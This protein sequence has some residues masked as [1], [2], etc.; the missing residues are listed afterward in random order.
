MPDVLLITNAQLI[1]G[2]PLG[3]NI[4]LDKYQSV[5]RDTQILT[6]EPILGTKLYNKILADYEANTLSG[7]YLELHTEYIVPILVHSTAAEYITISGFNVANG[8]IFR[9]TPENATPADKNEI[10][11][12]ANKQRSKADVYI[13]RLQK[14]LCDKNLPEYDQPQDENYDIK[15]DK[16][17]NTF[18]GW[19]LSRNRNFNTSLER[20]IW[21]DIW[22]DEGR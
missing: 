4:D 10:D 11:Y 9:Y 17:V 1:E 16:D 20:Y 18:S 6:L 5:I 13:Q 14:Y 8:G 12:L 15:P 2:S 19:R 3:G 21:E 22:N 7:D